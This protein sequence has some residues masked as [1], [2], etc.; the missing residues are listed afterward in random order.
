MII[1]IGVLTNR[2][3]PKECHVFCS[4]DKDLSEFIK[5][6]NFRCYYNQLRKRIN[7]IT[8][9]VPDCIDSWSLLS[10]SLGRRSHFL[11]LLIIMCCGTH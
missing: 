2:E 8:G 7:K 3:F 6:V 5:K 1:Q 11:I 9:V 4:Q 10:F